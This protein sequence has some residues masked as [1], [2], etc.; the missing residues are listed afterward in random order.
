MGKSP[1]TPLNST[2][3]PMP[4]RLVPLSDRAVAIVAA[5]HRA[6]K[7]KAGYVSRCSRAGSPMCS[8]QRAEV[9]GGSEERG[10]MAGHGTE[11]Q[12]LRRMLTGEGWRVEHT[13]GQHLRWRSPDGVMVLTGLTPGTHRWRVNFW[14][15]VRRQRR[16][17]EERVD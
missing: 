16:R 1:A 5:Q 11:I 2:I 4:S 9:A 12:K 10:V 17:R 7:D 14:S 3:S 6:A 13:G 8:F 15:E